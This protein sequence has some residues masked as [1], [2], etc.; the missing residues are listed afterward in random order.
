[1]AFSVGDMSVRQ[2]IDYFSIR[3]ILPVSPNEVRDRIIE[4]GFSDEIHFIPSPLNS[5]ILLGM[6]HSYIYRNGVYADPTVRVDITYDSIQP[7]ALQRLVCCKE[8]LHIFDTNTQKTTKRVDVNK[9]ISDLSNG[10]K[11]L[12]SFSGWS[13]HS[14]VD[15][16]TVLRAVAILFPMAARDTLIEPLN[17]G[18]ISLSQISIY[19]DLP[20]EFVTLVMSQ[21]W[22]D[23]HSTILSSC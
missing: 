16:I 11:A 8:L 2:L 5:T 17:S 4:M 19:A 12:D 3:T 15:A 6:H 9:L 7:T 10:M 13:I 1:M 21:S 23:L 18:K 20:E 14:L 22:N